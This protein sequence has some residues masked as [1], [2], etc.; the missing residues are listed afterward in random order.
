[1]HPGGRGQVLAAPEFDVGAAGAV[2]AIVAGGGV[3]LARRRRA[4]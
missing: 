4:R 3:L 1:V 2:A